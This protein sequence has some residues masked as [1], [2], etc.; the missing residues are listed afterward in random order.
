VF[1]TH[2][3]LEALNLGTRI[4]VL[5]AG[6]LEVVTT[7]EAFLEVKT[8]TALSFLNTLPPQLLAERGKWQT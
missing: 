8:P 4:A 3:L 6:Q 5:H 1:V 2:D 7:P